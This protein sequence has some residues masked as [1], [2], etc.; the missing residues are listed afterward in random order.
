MKFNNL[1]ILL[2]ISTFATAQ[3]INDAVRMSTS[4]PG[5]SARVMGAGSS[6]GAMGGD[7]GSLTINPAG[8]AD[9]RS[10]ELAFSLS[11]NYGNTASD[12]SGV[13]TL[14]TDH[15]K[16]VSLEN[17]GIVFHAK[18]RGKLVT[19][20]IA[21][22]LH[23]YN[24]FKQNFGFQGS[25][26]GS[27]TERFVE[28]SNNR[29]PDELDNFEAG[30]AFDTGAVFED[31][32]GGYLTDFIPS[33]IV[34][35]NQD[36]TRSGK[37]NEL[38]AAWG[39]KFKSNLNIGVALSVPFYSFEETKRYGESDFADEI[40]VFDD[41][42]F[43][44][45]LATSGTG[46][47]FKAGLTYTLAKLIRLGASFE[48]PTWIKLDDNYTTS[49]DY[50]FTLPPDPTS[51]LTSSSP[52]GRFDYRFKT[53]LRFNGSIGALVKT[54]NINGFV[55]FDAEYVDYASSSFNL[56]SAIDTPAEAAFE[57]ELNGEIS[58]ELQSV[59]NY[60]MGLELA[61]KKVR[62]RG[63]VGLLGSA[64]AQSSFDFNNLYAVGAGF[65]A[66]KVYFD[67][68]YQ[69]R[70][71]NEDYVPYQVLDQTR[72]QNISNSSDISKIT[73][74]IGYKL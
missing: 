52:D 60:N 41:L 72:L 10:S 66:D 26:E 37:I 20:N 58:N 14:D 46:F 48:S 47:N 69:L 8:I 53:P 11:Y 33:D 5:G 62:L 13:N 4:I 50:S 21:V 38:S 70:S 55:N 25:T 23:Q 51:R 61:Y 24:S 68:S 49:L 9:F 2:L 6:F 45:N 43:V 28:L 35:K 3:N 71:F 17:L 59:M 22:S 31:G 42:T 27:I 64:F 15:D 39:A 7:L 29:S 73:L 32:F 34:T 54:E 1:F 57:Q 44:E 40:P 36:I 12:F 56:T 30:L 19:S 74:S 65:R 67:L 63:G 16:Q 18:P